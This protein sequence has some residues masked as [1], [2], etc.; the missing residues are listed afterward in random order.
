MPLYGNFRPNEYKPL[1]KHSALKALELDANL[2]EA[3]ASLGYIINTYDFDW[4]G[5]EREYK[6]AIELNPNY[7][8]AHQWYAEHLAFKGKTDEALEEISKALE[9]DPFSV[10]INRM[11]GN[12][13]GFAKRYDEAI[14]QLR[15][16]EEL[17]P[18]NA[19]VKFNLGD[20]YA[21]QKMY[22]EAVEQYLIALRFDGEK[23]EDIQKFET[24]FKNHGWQGFWNEYLNS[25]LK[26]QQTILE[27][28]KNAYIN[29]E[30]IAF[31]YAATAN[32]GKTLEYLEKAYQ[33]RD[34]DLYSIKM[35]EVYD[36]LNDDPR[37]RELIKNIGLPE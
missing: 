12:I 4:E 15:K 22:S 6:K 24:A 13:L 33:E 3:H 19:L 10:V 2:A 31:A 17:Y 21:S 14:V 30:S 18:E 5:A 36:F 35:S 9:L 23:P 20:A 32:R 7:A 8:T 11:K 25:L 1:A 37:Y 27:T 28:D 16:T 29:S 34:P 26:Q